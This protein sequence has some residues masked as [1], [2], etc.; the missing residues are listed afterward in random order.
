MV[1]YPL[2][3]LP[4]SSD[5]EEE[6]SFEELNE[7]IGSKITTPTDQ[8]SSNLALPAAPAGVTSDYGSAS[9]LIASEVMNGPHHP[10]TVPNQEYWSLIG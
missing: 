2:L 6:D 3:S 9:D 10:G 5:G 4:A 1:D 8:D 7:Q